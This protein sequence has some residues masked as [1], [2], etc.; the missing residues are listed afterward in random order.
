MVGAIGCAFIGRFVRDLF[1]G[2]HDSPP[3]RRSLIDE[4]LGSGSD[5]GF[6][7]TRCRRTVYFAGMS[8]SGVVTKINGTVPSLVQVFRETAA[9]HPQVV[10]VE[11][12]R[13]TL[14]YLELDRL[15]DALAQELRQTGT[16]TTSPVGLLA[17]RSLEMV[18]ALVAC[19]KAGR[20]YVPLDPMYPADR[21]RFMLDNSKAELLLAHDALTSLV[22]GYQGRTRSLDGLL[23]ALAAVEA[24]STPVTES[25][26]AYVIYTS[27]STGTPKGVAMGQ[28]ALDHLIDW[29][30]RNTCV[31]AFG[32]TLQFSPLSFDVS[33]QETLATLCSGGTLV[34]IDAD[35]RL[36]S[37]RL[38]DFLR[39]QRI[40]RLFLPF[41]ALQALAEASQDVSGLALKE[42]VTAGEQ[43]VVTPA[44]QRFFERV[45]GC[46]LYNHYGPSETHVV[47]SH[48][49]AAAPAE[50]P[51]LPP[52]GAA[53]DGARLYILD[54]AQKPVADGQSGELYI[55]GAL[56]ADGYAGSLELTQERFLPDPFEAGGRMYRTGDL[57]CRLESGPHQGELSYL[58]RI[59]SQVKIRGFR[60]ELGEVEA[61]L[62]RHAQVSQAAVTARQDNDRP[63]RLV[64]YVVTKDSTSLNASG[65][66][67]HLLPLLPDY[68][69]PSTYVFLNELPRTPSGKIDRRALPA[70]ERKRP[71]LN[72]P[73]VAAE[74]ENE[75][76]I[77]EIWAELLELD[78]VGLDDDFFELGGTSLLALQFVR[79]LAQRTGHEPGIAQLFD[80]TTPRALAEL[81]SGEAGEED[82]LAAAQVRRR[83]VRHGELEPIAIVGWAGRFPGAPSVETLAGILEQG[84][85]GVT[86][87]APHEL[88]PRI[89]REVREDP[90][91]V[92]AR[93]IIA[94]PDLFDNELFGISPREA[95]VTDPQQRQLLELSW[96]ALEDA[97]CDP[98]TYPGPI[99][100]F[101]GVMNNSYY[102]ENVQHN[103]RAVEGFGAFN[104]MTANEKDYAATRI[105]HRLNLHGPSVSVHT[106]CSTS[107]VATHLACQSLRLHECDVALAGGASVNVPVAAGY[108]YNEGG[109]LSADGHCR[110]FD[111]KAT[112]TTFGDGAA[113][114]VLKRL[115][116]ALTDGDVIH[117]VILGSAI[118]NDGASKASF[119]AP[120][121]E[122]QAR[123]IG[124]ALAAANVSPDSVGYVE[125][126]GTATPIG[127]P[128]EVSAL[129][130]AYGRRSGGAPSCALGSIK[131]NFG[132][133]TAA[134]GVA[135]LIKAALSVERNTIFPTLHFENL[136]PSID[137]G[138]RFF[139]AD[140]T[141][142]FDS[143]MNPRRA[144]VSSMGVGGTNA[145]V[146]LEQPPPP[147]ASSASRPYQTFRLSARTP[148]ALTSYA[149]TLEQEVANGGMTQV[150]DL[151][152]TLAVGRKALRYRASV[153]ARDADELL[154]ELRK[155]V[156][157]VETKPQPVAFVFPGQGTQYPHMAMGLYDT[158]PTFRAAMDQ[159]AEAVSSHLP[160]P[161]VELIRGAGRSSEEA[162]SLLQETRYAQPA[163]FAVEYSLAQL[164]MSL[165]FQPTA[166]VGHSVGEFVAATLAGVF[167]LE[168]AIRLV[169]T[170]GQVMQG[171]DAGG[172]LSVRETPERVQELLV[173]QTELAAVN[174]KKLVVAAGPDE[175]LA[176]LQKK[177][178]ELDIPCKRLRTSHAFHTWMMEPAVAQLRAALADVRLRAPQVPFVSTA[179]GDWIED[180]EATDP[181]Y[182]ASHLRRT[183]LFSRALQSLWARH[184]TVLLE[185]GPAGTL[186]ALAR[187]SISDPVTVVT[188]L[189]PVGDAA[190]E[191]R[192]FVRSLGALW[193]QGVAHN[194]SSIFHHEVRRKLA[195]PPRPLE[196]KSHW[197][198]PLTDTSSGA[199]ATSGAAA[200]GAAITASSLT[201]H[202]SLPAVTASVQHSSHGAT[203]GASPTFSAANSFAE[204]I[205]T[206][207]TPRNALINEVR[208]LLEDASGLELASFDEHAQFTEMG[209]DSLLLTQAA[210]T[211]KKRFSVPVT[212]RQLSDELSS[213]ATVA[214]YLLPALPPEKLAA[215]SPAQQPVAA[216]LAPT[217]GPA[218]AQAAVSVPSP[219]LVAPAAAPYAVQ[220]V[221]STGALAMTGAP[222]TT[223]ALPTTGANDATQL[224]IQQ[225]I[226]L[227]ARQLELLQGSAGHPSALMGV[228]AAVA[229]PAQGAQGVAAVAP[230]SAS[231]G[232]SN[233]ASSS[234]SNGASNAGA[235]SA[236]ANQNAGLSKAANGNATGAPPKTFGAQARIDAT[237]REFDAAFTD[238]LKQFI[239]RYVSKTT[240]SKQ[241]TAKHRAHLADPRVVS[242]F[243]PA[244]KEATYP[245]VVERS[246]GCRLWDI[247]GNEYIDIT[248]GFGTNFLGHSPD[249]VNDAVKAQLDRGVEIGPQ[250]P[251]A[252]EVAQLMAE[253]TGLDRA[254]LCNTGSEAVLGA[255]RLARTVTGN[256][257]IVMFN[258]AY[259]GIVDEV[260]VRGTPNLK[261]FPA[262]PGIPP[263]AVA[264]TLILDYGDPKSL[265]IIRDRI[266][267]LAA[268]LVEPVQSRHP[269]LQPRDFLH[270][271]RAITEQAGVALI[272]DE[273]ITGFRIC[274]GGAQAHFGVQ[275]DLATYGKIIGGGMPIGAIAGKR[276]FMDALD[277]GGWQFGDD[278]IPEIGVTYF[279]G[280]FVRHPLALAASKAALGF[281]K[282]QGPEL[283][284][285]IN[286]KTARLVDDLNGHFERHQS[287]VHIER[288]GS[289]FKIH[290][291]ES[292]PLV[293]LFFHA[294][295]VRGIH[296]W[297]ARPSFITFAHSDAD[298][299]AIAAAFKGAAADMVDLGVFPPSPVAERTTAPVA[300]ARLGRDSEGKA[301]WFTEDP[302]RP[303]KYLRVSAAE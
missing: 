39:D 54:D 273:V 149:Q 47:T 119:T 114:V 79:E 186:P 272:F 244:I 277:G 245:I 48:L 56:L 213:I 26:L 80:R 267:E 167:R 120:S 63:K 174:G 148:T 127:D 15:T 225:Q 296:V 104:T 228:N 144:A 125:G 299:D 254:A 140:K 13:H 224:L 110:A 205:A 185:L 52:I 252:G 215:L 188:A 82:Y 147:R 146:V 11:H 49:L 103:R 294:L 94:G 2:R 258:G 226:Q 37:P 229:V 30:L 62:A 251:L 256:S 197:I 243:R 35:V 211:F 270:E 151:A 95:Q 257:L 156:R 207:S 283:Q 271:L 65:L 238:K 81:L 235:G 300:G 111:A 274:P 50:W 164:F 282:S 166:C 204:P 171:M 268:V 126:H 36:D 259:H 291:E 176:V 262:A 217:P 278:S 157:P 208:Q 266:D 113:V 90:A 143:A 22:A 102:A 59:D 173:P 27:G 121:V 169:A 265:E 165:G 281:L 115:S 276:R 46:R 58:G 89:P 263:E 17:N 239:E 21:L 25:G 137:L 73:Y 124:A 159:C 264:N 247:D 222:S 6:S 154:A 285:R 134:A 150:A 60:V 5:C 64:A 269:D 275:A 135:G 19:L 246:K 218:V 109:M 122:G 96:L 130:K 253:M 16:T 203:T 20:G 297:E 196:R 160:I 42:V 163:L 199:G 91:Y 84:I 249:F 200:S 237:K 280:T 129:V 128:I 97:A 180:R 1:S 216:A 287:P 34:L 260:I 170:R 261:S 236:A 220:M 70:P 279:A 232:A 123:V 179:T 9:A 192:A 55:G 101:A 69:L 118:N 33:F 3:L 230:L 7:W 142:A 141:A 181:E 161:L 214:D 303:G 286:A 68:M 198:E 71:E 92:S 78:R 241:Y 85:E 206:M 289:L 133:L 88:D 112:G 40:D 242:G 162:A 106:A 193:E 292:H 153:V 190:S 41:V 233:G 234:A 172:M 99:G 250:N 152:Y 139:V 76:A 10:A 290:V 182:W 83:R 31:L 298:V 74:S 209:L 201:T 168:D 194:A 187:H 86:F 189:G 43:L 158:E 295:R 302:E 202:V 23:E 255:M 98:E 45:P 210:L 67:Q 87:F 231:N 12:G 131:S 18:V 248:C 4:L 223:G 8:T 116:D 191:Q 195:L 178:E 24:T 93:G 288:F 183:V 219:A 38:R 136:N 66:R 61:A 57:V 212:F 177:L 145:H 221:S 32:R 28:R 29:Q 53:V 105:S 77:C 75:R 14:T 293:A 184:K 284:E 44:I 100:V 72:T 155:G 240:R 107:L 108:V 138:G 132:H 51:K 301:A 227:M 175:A 117:A